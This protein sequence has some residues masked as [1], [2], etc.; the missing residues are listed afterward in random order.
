MHLKNFINAC[1]MYTSI[2][3]AEKNVLSTNYIPEG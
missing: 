1:T 3:A 2:L